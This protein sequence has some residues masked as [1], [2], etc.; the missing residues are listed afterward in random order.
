MRGTAARGPRRRTV[1]WVLDTGLLGLLHA[2]LAHIYLDDSGVSKALALGARV[3][4]SA[5]ER[6]LRR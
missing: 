5:D 2:S 4:E 1:P 6:R 3:D